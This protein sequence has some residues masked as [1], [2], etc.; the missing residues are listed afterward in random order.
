MILDVVSAVLAVVG[1]AFFVAGTVGVL[2]FPDLRSRLHAIT[3]ADNLG[4]GL[5]LA[6]LALQALSPAVAVKLGLVWLLALLA[7]STISFLLAAEPPDR[8]A[9]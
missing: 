5:V 9:S 1:C 3:K 4:L 7:S 6:A 8:A 2:R